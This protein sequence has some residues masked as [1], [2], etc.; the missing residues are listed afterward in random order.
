MTRSRPVRRPRP[1]HATPEQQLPRATATTTDRWISAG[2][3]ALPVYG[4]L[5]FWSTLEPQPDQV[6]DPAG[7]ASF[8]STGSYLISHLVGSTVGIILAIFGVFALGAVLA[9]TRSAGLGLTGMVLTV[10]GQGLLM[11]PSVISTFATPAIGRAY[12][13]GHPDV[14]SV[15]FPPA[16]TAT[17]AL[18]LLLALVGNVSLG[19][20][21]WRSDRLPRWAGAIW[22]LS[23]VVFYVL[24][25]VL[26]LAT[27]GASLPTQPVGALLV[28]VAGGWIVWYDARQRTRGPARQSQASTV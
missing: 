4:A 24:G 14:M 20:A 9:R 19:I 13:A 26:G 27:T 25:V 3:L 15:E 23:A 21:V 10:A 11:V 1:D 8:V 17:F 6:K 2:L 12:R 7:W 16:M 22:A 18:G 5:T 28:V